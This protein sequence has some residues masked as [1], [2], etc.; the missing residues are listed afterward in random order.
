MEMEF[1][2]YEFPFKRDIEKAPETLQVDFIN[3]QCNTILTQ[4]CSE[5][6]LQE[7]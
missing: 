4:T 1:M 6:K 3:L 7:F 5:I 2:L